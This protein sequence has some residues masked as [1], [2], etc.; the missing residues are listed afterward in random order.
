MVPLC[1]FVLKVLTDCHPLV[2]LG[3]T[4]RKRARQ[5]NK[6]VPNVLINLPLKGVDYLFKGFVALVSKVSKFVNKVLEVLFAIREIIKLMARE[7]GQVYYSVP[8][9]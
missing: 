4:R 9:V 8:L 3:L 1:D 5:G 7:E 6:Q 2:K